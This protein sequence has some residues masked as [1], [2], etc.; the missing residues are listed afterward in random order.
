MNIK[1]IISLGDVA[2]MLGI[3]HETARR[4]AVSQKIPAF[5]YD[6]NGRWRAYREDID[7]WVSE[8]QNRSSAG[9]AESAVEK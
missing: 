5:R 1:T 2:K 6:E 8:R 9:Q 4:W 7:N 3:D